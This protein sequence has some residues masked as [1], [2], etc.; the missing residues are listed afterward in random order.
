M[1]ASARAKFDSWSASARVVQPV[2]SDMT[3]QL[4]GMAYDD[5][6]VLRF[7]GAN[8]GS[9]GEDVSARLIG[10]GDWQFDV[11]GY[12]QW[13]NF[14]NTVIS[15]T[16][17]VPVLE[18]K[19]TPASGQGGK[20][21]I[22]PP[23]GGGHTLRFGADYRRTQGDLKEDAYSAFSG[24]RT[25]Q[26]FAG[27]VNTDAG[28]FVEDD[29]ELGRLTLTGGLRADHYT[30]R[31]GYYRALNG[32]GT[33]V[34]TDDTYGN[35]AD[36]EVSW[37][38]GAVFA[39]TEALDLR[40]AAYRGLRLPTVN[41]LYRPFVVFPVTTEANANLV[42]ETLE[43]FDVGLDWQA[44]PGIKLTATYFDNVVND[45]IT[46][47]TIGTNLRQRRNI[48]AIDAEG[49]E[50]GAEL[51]SG[52]FGFDG[53]LAYTNAKQQGTGFASALDGYTPSQ[54]PK[55]A[56]SA[57]ASYRPADGALVAATLRHVGKQYE[58]DQETDVLP[59]ATTLDLFAQI[60]LFG[61]LS[62]VARAENV[63]DETIVTRNQGG[64]MDLG[65]PRT[66]WAGVRYGF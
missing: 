51:R 25:E 56:A 44:M 49:F 9:R 63:F 13:R 33:T 54:T 52:P 66:V 58:D 27:G 48:Q 10:R 35:R 5:D 20:V 29:W 62:F 59:A 46:N 7:K 24:A 11:I 3:L 34:L 30:I 18:Q 57:T 21:E 37:R 36:W 28:F 23:V 65:A 50:F 1:P 16:R 39:A 26:R 12:L 41:E 61:A 43:G 8:T 19:D 45:A 4:R 32:A 53:S 60:P 17:F 42:P 14:H 6:R 47:V 64:S 55:W 2:G 40:A 31:D 22:R 38:G 15:S